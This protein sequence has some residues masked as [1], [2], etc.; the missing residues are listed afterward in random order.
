MMKGSGD[1]D[2]GG[3]GVAV[4]RQEGDKIWKGRLIKMHGDLD[5]ALLSFRLL[6][7]YINGGKTFDNSDERPVTRLLTYVL[8]KKISAGLRTCL[9]YNSLHHHPHHHHP[10]HYYHHYHHYRHR[11]PHHHPHYHNHPDYH[12]HHHLYHHPYHHHHY[13][14]HHHHHHTNMYTTFVPLSKA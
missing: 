13:H 5:S 4:V 12:H 2:G 3:N 8:R 1:C 10:H 14:H 9:Y 6:Y 11:H 7:K